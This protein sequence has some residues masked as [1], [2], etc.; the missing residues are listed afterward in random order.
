MTTAN[1]YGIDSMFYTGNSPWQ[2]VGTPLD[3]A[4]TAEEAI[5]AAGLDWEVGL[6]RVFVET[7]D[8]NY[9][10]D[11]NHKGLARLDT[12]KVFNY[13][14][15]RY[16]PFQNRT[17]FDF[18][19]IFQGSLVFHSA[20]SLK[21]GA[22][23]F[24]YSMY[25]EPLVLPGGETIE[26]GILLTTT[27]DG[28]GSVHARFLDNRT[29]CCNTL[30]GVLRMGRGQAHEFKAM[31][32]RSLE[33]KIEEARRFMGLEDAHRK[34]LELTVNSLANTRISGYEREQFLTHLFGQQENP[35]EIGTRIRNQM[36][37]VDR[38]F[39]EGIGNEGW[40]RWDMLNGV[41]EFTTHYK[42]VR[43]G[44]SEKANRLHANWF[45]TGRRLNDSAMKLLME[46]IEGKL[47]P[48]LV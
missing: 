15:N 34:A 41:T 1:R 19:S 26:M 27:H 45:G 4:A 39:S 35:L 42:G 44:E 29:R 18:S 14:S 20:G 30:P 10:E 16:E 43:G 36:D 25:P 5:V 46:G 22:I 11:P 32:T 31:H 48:V 13:F 47:S 33:S 9:F 37:E 17:A 24:L 6:R 2:G 3:G 28:S 23:V 21:E 8:G 7:S 12:G 38:L 40:S